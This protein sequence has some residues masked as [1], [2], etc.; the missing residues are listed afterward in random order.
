MIKY[1]MIYVFSFAVLDVCYVGSVLSAS[2]FGISYSFICS[3]FYPALV[4]LP[5][6]MAWRPW[7]YRVL[8]GREIQSKSNYLLVYIH[9]SLAIGAM[10]LSP[11]LR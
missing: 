9:C 6:V 2:L 3:T 4:L 8:P 1:I 10:D 7:C 11:G 5:Q